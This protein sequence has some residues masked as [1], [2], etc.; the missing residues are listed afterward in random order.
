MARLTAFMTG[1]GG[2]GKSTGATNFAIYQASQGR[3]V[4]MLDFDP[5][6]SLSGW[7]GLRN[8]E[9]HQTNPLTVLFHGNN[10]IDDV[11]AT[12]NFDQFDE[13]ILDAPGADNENY[14]CMLKHVDFCV[15]P[16]LAGGFDRLEVVKNIRFLDSMLD[17]QIDKGRNVKGV[18]FLNK[19]KPNSKKVRE[20]RREYAEITKHMLIAD[21]EL[22]MLNDFSD[23]VDYGLSVL[24][25]DPACR[26]AEQTR[27]WARELVQIRDEP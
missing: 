11:M 17:I 4:L 2:S 25:L 5:Q 8:E 20:A 7:F 14:R 10:P 9:D 22:G 3:K 21:N 27:D 1:K 19:T 13:V 24:E 18:M 6:S 23:A 15:M 12:S 16:V 26:A